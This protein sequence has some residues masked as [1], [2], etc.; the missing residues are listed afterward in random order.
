MIAAG[1]L[2][3]QLQRIELVVGEALQPRATGANA[4]QQRVMD[5]PIG[6]HKGVA[7]G[8]GLNRRQVG[9]EATGKQQ[10]TLALKPCSQRGFELL[11]HAAPTAHQAR[12]TGAHAFA[13]HRLAGG[14]H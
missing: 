3:A 2:Q 6:E 4:H 1:L 8:Q 9:L 5:Q 13:L 11:M 10:H 7:I 14:L 12:C